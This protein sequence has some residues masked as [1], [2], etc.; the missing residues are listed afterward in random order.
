MTAQTRMTAQTGRCG[1]G[2]VAKATIDDSHGLKSG[3]ESQGA[4]HGQT[5]CLGDEIGL[6]RG[7]S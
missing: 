6:L 5:H 3:A 2:E 7:R 4:A 1:G